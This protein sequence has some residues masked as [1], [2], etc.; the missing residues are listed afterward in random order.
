M[1]RLR[2]SQNC[3]SLAAGLSSTSIVRPRSSDPRDIPKEN[4]T[5]FQYSHLISA[6]WNSYTIV[7]T[8]DQPNAPWGCKDSRQQG[9][10]VGANASSSVRHDRCSGRDGYTHVRVCHLPR[11]EADERCVWTPRARGR[12]RPYR[13]VECMTLRIGLAFGLTVVG[14][15]VGRR[16]GTPI[17]DGRMVRGF[18]KWC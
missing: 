4:L 6:L 18:R 3:V 7:A 14:G 16:R 13:M 1:P 15:C 12:L 17:D 8:T 9:K 5:Q 2:C 11:G 10:N